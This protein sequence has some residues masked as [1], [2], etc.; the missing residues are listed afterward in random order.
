[1]K[2]LRRADLALL[3]ARHALP[4]AR[5]VTRAAQTLPSLGPAR[6]GR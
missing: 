1:V 6:S 4:E 5:S 2:A 3:V